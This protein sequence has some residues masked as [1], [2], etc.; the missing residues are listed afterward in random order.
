[1]MMH[2]K[3]SESNSFPSKPRGGSETVAHARLW[4]LGRLPDGITDGIIR[5]VSKYQELHYKVESSLE[6]SS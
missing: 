5:M 4:N 6:S 1:M 2:V 3:P